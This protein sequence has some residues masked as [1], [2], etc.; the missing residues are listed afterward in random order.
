VQRHVGELVIQLDAARRVFED[1]GRRWDAADPATRGVLAS[2]AK[3][4]ATEAALR[5]TEK[6]VQLVGG[7]GAFRDHPVERAYRDVRTCTLMTPTAD[8][9][10]ETIGKSALGLDT[11]MLTVASGR[12]AAS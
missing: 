7:R 9:M 12:Q 1:A 2:K 3:Y 10:V 8:R 4:M 5:V 6:A 11:A